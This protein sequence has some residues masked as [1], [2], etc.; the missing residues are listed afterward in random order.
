MSSQAKGSIPPTRSTPAPPAGPAPSPACGGGV[1]RGARREGPARRPAFAL[2]G[3]SA[4]PWWRGRPFAPSPAL[5]RFAGERVWCA[6]WKAG[7]RLPQGGPRFGAPCLLKRREASRRHAPRPRRPPALLPLPRS[8]GGLGRGRVGK[9]RRGGPL[10]PCLVLQRCLGGAVAL[11]PPPL[12]SPASRERESGAP[13]GEPRAGFGKTAGDSAPRVFSSEEKH[14]AD[15]LHARAARRPCSLSRLRGR[16]GE[17]AARERAGAGAAGFVFSLPGPTLSA[18]PA[19]LSPPWPFRPL[20]HPPPLRGRGGAA[21]RR[22]Q[23]C[24][25]RESNVGLIFMSD[26]M[27]IRLF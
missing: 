23:S 21:R 17:G 13:G 8:G 27:I 3:S 19:H 20:P 22:E 14:P 1:G 15:T 26:C 7:C 25:M 2:P 6:G 4:L 10:S 9:G 11:S 12:P 18:T 5:P 24:A 16:A